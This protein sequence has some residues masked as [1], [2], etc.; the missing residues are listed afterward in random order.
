[1][2]FR[3][4]ILT[5]NRPASLAKLL[6]SVN[7]LVLDGDRG[8]LEIFIDVARDTKSPNAQTKA[9]AEGFTWK[10]GPTWVHVQQRHVGIYGQWI[11]SWRPLVGHK[12]IA[13]I[14]EDDMSVSKYAYRWLKAAHNS[15]GGRPDV[16]GYTLQSEEVG[17][18]VKRL[19]LH[20]PPEDTVFLY[21]VLGSW[22]FSPHPVIWTQF[23]DWYHDTVGK[24]HSFHPYVDGI[25]M[26]K[27]YKD[28]EKAGSAST[29]WT[30]WFIYFTHK[31][32]LFCL[33]SNLNTYL[34][35]HK[36]CLTVH[37]QE[38]GLHYSGQARNNEGNLLDLWEDRF[39]RFPARTSMYDYDGTSIF[40]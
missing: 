40:H 33:Y 4:I 31:H 38:K 16:Q 30:M 26:T 22:G 7:E 8:S 3:I 32:N 39:V 27:W 13:L 29:M 18:A 36:A 20:G 37:R 6:V 24:N 11:D 5:F 19:H 34:H 25:A 2:D 21:R 9:I 12:E 17:D 1:M 23:Q 28:F 14:L 35:T 15:F 10:S